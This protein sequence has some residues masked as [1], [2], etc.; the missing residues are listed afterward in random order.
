MK[1]FARVTAQVAIVELTVK[2][3]VVNKNRNGYMECYM[4]GI[5][6]HI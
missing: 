6:M 3:S 4:L 5:C 2:V 1:E